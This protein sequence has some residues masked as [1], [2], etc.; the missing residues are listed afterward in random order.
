MATFAEITAQVEIGWTYYT[1]QLNTIRA[2]MVEGCFACTACDLSCLSAAILSLEYDIE[3]ENNTDLTTRTYNLLLSILSG[4]TGTFTAD[5]T[6]VIEG[7]SIVAEAGVF[8]QTSVVYP[9]EGA[10]SY[11]FPELIGQN[12]LT[13][14]RGS[15]TVLRAHSSGPDN[16]FAQFNSATGLITLNYAFSEGESLWVAYQTV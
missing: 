8:E 6:V 3:T 4:F 12:V 11:T 15:G 1:Q 13:V 2:K 9:A 5:P 7:V 14:Y 10:V 16:E